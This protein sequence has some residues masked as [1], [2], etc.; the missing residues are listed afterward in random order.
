[1]RNAGF[2]IKLL[3]IASL[4]TGLGA[5][6]PAPAQQG[7]PVPVQPED[8]VSFDPEALV[9]C[10]PKPEAPSDFRLVSRED[11]VRFAVNNSF[12]VKLA[13]LDLYVAETELMYVEAVFDTFLYGGVG[14]TEDKRQEVS[15]FAPDKDLLN[16]YYAGVTKTLPTGTE[17]TVEAGDTRLW[18]N[19]PFVAK[20]PSHTAELS[21]E[22]KQPV[23]KN[24]FGYVDRKKI[25]LTKLAIKNADLE[26]KDRIE[27]LIAEVERSYMDLVFAKRS[28][29]IF[30]GILEKAKNLYEV[31]RKN[32]DIGLREKVDLFSSEA[33]VATREAEVLV[34]ENNYKRAEENLKLM[35]NMS[36]EAR[37]APAEAFSYG[38]MDKSLPVC[39]KE[40]FEKRRDY[41]MKKRDVEIM[42]LNLKIKTNE[43]WPEIDLIASMAMN[44]CETKFRKAAGK[45]VVMDNTYYYAGVEFKIPIENRQARSEFDKAGYEKESALVKLKEVERTIITEVG[46]AFR[47]VLAY[48]ASLAYMHKAVELQ[49]KKLAEEEKRFSYGRSNTKNIIDYQRDLLRAE[50]EEAKFMLDHARANIDLARAMNVILDK[51][52]DML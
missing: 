37:I 23:G 35:M 52:E 16:E 24:G 31:D 6:C 28:L 19:T 2:A 4:L 8:T 33:N 47:N 48:E 14:W 46:N 49:S 45:T 9:S 40:A 29:D 25:T 11:C 34:A 3:F 5:Y 43:K 50:L 27:A 12:E 21:F 42:G 39:L 30:T 18:N 38:Y 1:M 32:L 13:K 36:D 51:Y 44:G 7:N 15:V 17:V 22:I 10:G 26:M 41:Y 20:N